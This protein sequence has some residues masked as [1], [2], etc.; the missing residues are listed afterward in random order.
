[1]TDNEVALRQPLEKACDATFLGGMIC[2][3]ADCLMAPETETLCGAAPGERSAGRTNQ[4]N[5][6]HERDWHARAG[7]VE[8]HIPKLRRGSCFPGFLQPREIA[9]KALTAVIQEAHFQSTSTRP[10]GDLVKVIGGRS[11]GS[12]GLAGGKRLDGLGQHS[13]AA[14]SGPTLR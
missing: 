9:E 8:L 4:R 3:N 7:T 13:L 1:M 12:D 2:F 11:R 6:Y 5:G 10:V 14:E